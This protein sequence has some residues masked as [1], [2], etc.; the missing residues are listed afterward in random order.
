M[1]PA[2]LNE[3]LH[4]IFLIAAL[5]AYRCA[6]PAIHYLTRLLPDP[7]PED[8]ELLADPLEAEFIELERQVAERKRDALKAKQAEL[9]A[10]YA[11]AMKRV[12]ATR[13]WPEEYVEALREVARLREVVHQCDRIGLSVDEAVAT[14]R[15]CCVLSSSDR[16]LNPVE[17]D[18]ALKQEQDRWP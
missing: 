13:E 2:I 7:P 16:Y 11:E 14:W 15:R 3:I 12:V 9:N 6:R 10:K 18:T 8:D 5:I 1:D 17:Q 4:L